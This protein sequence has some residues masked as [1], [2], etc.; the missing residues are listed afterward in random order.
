MKV[1]Q[2]L[3][4]HNNNYSHLE[5]FNDRN[6]I[7]SSIVIPVYNRIHLLEKTLRHLRSH[8]TINQHKDSF[9]VIIVNDGSSEQ[10]RS[11]LAQCDLPC[12]VVYFNYT[13]NKGCSSAR[14]KGIELAQNELIFFVDS[15]VLVPEDYF[16]ESWK[17]HNATE[18]AL[19]VGF[20]DNL[21][22]ADP[23]LEELIGNFRTR[24]NFRRDFRHDYSDVKTGERASF[25]EE[26]DWFRSFNY[27]IH[28]C[29]LTL[30]EMVVT[31]NLSARKSNI[32]QVGRFD[33]NFIG[34]GYED[35][36]LGAKLIAAG[37]YVI[38][39]KDTGVFRIK[40][41]PRHGSWKD[42]RRQTIL[43]MIVYHAL[44]EEVLG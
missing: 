30:P 33:E 24:P 21:T 42:K 5:P 8:P 2:S 14:N 36:H 23:R 40:H 9:E 7:P 13:T 16:A 31:H 20:A 6:P 44:L 17:I 19:V 26:T 25:A 38:P 10:I 41:P 28:M 27:G 22:E 39:L 43:N 4:R 34:W 35:T 1:K 29:G 37:C 32:E 18:K 12:R 3:E 15:D 11:V